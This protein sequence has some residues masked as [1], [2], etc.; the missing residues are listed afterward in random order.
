MQ[1]LTNNLFCDNCNRKDGEFMYNKENIKFDTENINKFLK[2]NGKKIVLGTVIS[3]TI[4]TSSLPFIMNGSKK[5]NE[6]VETTSSIQY[7]VED[8]TYSLEDLY[9][10]KVEDTTYLCRQELLSEEN[11]FAQ[12][13]GL[14]HLLGYSYPLPLLGP[15]DEKHY[16]Y[17]DVKKMNL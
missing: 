15:N 1:E 2:D 5:Y 12:N 14:P 3:A 8:K 17:Y 7:V 16:L 9:Y 6:F 4:I 11:N 13:M 10:V